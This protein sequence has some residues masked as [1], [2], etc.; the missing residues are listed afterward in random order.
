MNVLLTGA[1]GFLGSRVV[2]ELMARG[3][4]VSALRRTT[5]NAWRLADAEAAIDWY[6]L[7]EGGIEQAF[8]TAPVDAVVHTAT[9]YGRRGESISE[10]LHTN[11]ALPVLL[12]ERAIAAR[13]KTFVT[14]GTV[15][16]AETSDYARSKQQFSA[17]ARRMTTGTP[18]R[19]VEAAIELMFGPM[20][21]E[22]K[23]VPML[24]QRCLQGDRPIELTLGEQRRDLVYVDDVARAVCLLAEDHRVNGRVEVGTG[25]AISIRDLA[26]RVRE[27]TR[28]EADLRFGAL[29][30]RPHEVMCYRADVRVMKSLGWSPQVALDDG[31]DRTIAW[32]RDREGVSGGVH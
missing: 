1:T 13:V 28:S 10:I 21:D 9:S 15:L 23:L 7:D 25:Q 6:P 31:L 26:L 19:F 12:L 27:R 11:L 2:R 16:P 17:W 14:T 29:E 24:V 30:Y 8:A 5:S 20:D 32:Y 4:R 22:W 3:H 18:T